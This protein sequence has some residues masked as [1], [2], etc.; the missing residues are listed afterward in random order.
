MWTNQHAAPTSILDE[1]EAQVSLRKS[2]GF[3]HA[4]IGNDRRAIAWAH[5]SAGACSLVERIR[6]TQGP[7]PLAVVAL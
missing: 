5:S 4:I 2:L 7:Q 1:P 6:L 3:S